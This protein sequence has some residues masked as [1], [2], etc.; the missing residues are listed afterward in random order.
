MNGSS[1][2]IEPPQQR[3]GVGCFAKGCLILVVFFSLLGCA[4][5][6]GYYFAQKH[7][8]FSSH[9]EPLPTSPDGVSVKDRVSL[10][11]LLVVIVSSLRY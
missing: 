3:H 4:F 9:H 11:L 8:Y 10:T 2:W 6:A 7:D 5:V 1:A